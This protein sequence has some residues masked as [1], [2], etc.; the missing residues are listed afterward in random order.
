MTLFQRLTQEIF[1]AWF[2]QYWFREII[3]VYH[4]TLPVIIIYYFICN[5]YMESSSYF[6]TLAFI[7]TTILYAVAMKPALK[8]ETI[9]DDTK[10]LEYKSNNLMYLG[11][12][13]ILVTLVQF[14]INSSIVIRI[15]YLK[16]CKFLKPYILI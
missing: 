8:L 15:L 10:Y 5:K 16:L 9:E 6:N 2:G 12:Y 11:A 1:Y 3:I 7:L 4:N 13:F 14:S